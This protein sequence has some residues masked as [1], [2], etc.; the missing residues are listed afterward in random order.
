MA[1][2]NM[3]ER[4]TSEKRVRVKA[5]S[6]ALQI[7]FTDLTVLLSTSPLMV[8]MKLYSSKVLSREVLDKMRSSSGSAMEQAFDIVSVVTDLVKIDPNV[9]DTFCKV[10]ESDSS[11]E[12]QAKALQGK[13]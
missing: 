2:E 8:S 9:F 11:T 7:N 10:L 12:S 3:S 13:Y 5:A 6:E 4:L 1:E